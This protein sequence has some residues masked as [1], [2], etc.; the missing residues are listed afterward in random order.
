MAIDKDKLNNE[1]P[2]V[3]IRAGL[4]GDIDDGGFGGGSG[5]DG[6]RGDWA[7]GRP[8]ISAV[9][10]I[11]WL[12]V[13]MLSIM[14]TA[15]SVVL[16]SRLPE[17]GTVPFQ[18]PHV[19]WLN[20]GILLLSSLALRQGYRQLQKEDQKG[21]VK[22]LGLA[23]GLGMLFLIGQLVAWAQLYS[24]GVHPDNHVFGGFFYLL[25][26]LHGVHLMSG[27]FV[28]GWLFIGARSGQFSAG[29]HLPV[30]MGSLYWHFLDVLWL[31]LFVLLSVAQTRL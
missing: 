27:V 2:E 23:L 16:I 21:L 26:A 7:Q 12:A 28:L 5:G 11:V 6:G 24:T 31:C 13:V 1:I 3:I 4:A 25:S 10:L 9:R 19:V 29:N 20:T 8:P 18:I 17:R 22:A 14:F 15:V 30:E